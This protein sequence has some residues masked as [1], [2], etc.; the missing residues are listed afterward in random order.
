MIGR[1]SAIGLALLFAFSFC[2][3]AAQSAVAQV[4]TKAVNTTAVTCIKGG[5]AEDFEDPHCD[6][7]V[8][9]GSGEYGHVAVANDETRELEVTNVGAAKLNANL[10]GVVTEV[11]CSKMK[12]ASE[13]AF[14]HNVETEKKHTMTGEGTTLF[15]EC[16]VL[17]PSKCIVKEPIS[18]A[19]TFQGI[20][21]LGAGKNEMGVEFV[22]MGEQKT[23]AEISFANKGAESCA[24]LNGGKAWIVKGSAIGTS[25]GSQTNKHAGATIVFESGKEMQTIEMGAKAAQVA[26]TITPSGAGGGPP[27][28][29]TTGT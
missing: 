23:L 4:G 6:K 7:F 9:V 8:G 14:V 10:A 21:G 26:L 5:G 18:S 25:N 29:I 27:I 20:E 12:A 2:A 19:G 15:S 28:S 17:K 13:K 22:G 11:T 16:T 24:L 3:L 1:R